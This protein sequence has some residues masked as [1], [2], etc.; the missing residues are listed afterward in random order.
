MDTDFNVITIL[1]TD[2]YEYWY[3]NDDKVFQD[4]M[5]PDARFILD[6]AREYHPFILREANLDDVMGEN[7]F[8]LEDIYYYETLPELL[9]RLTDEERAHFEELMQTEDF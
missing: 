1:K 7:D 5:P 4:D 6:T 3:V 9:E 2:D 8:L